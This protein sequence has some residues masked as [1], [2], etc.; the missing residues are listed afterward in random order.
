MAKTHWWI[1]EDCDLGESISV[2]V[3]SPLIHRNYIARP[4]RVHVW[5]SSRRV[6]V[7]ADQNQPA[8]GWK[9]RRHDE[10]SSCRRI[11]ARSVHSVHRCPLCPQPSPAARPSPTAVHLC[12]LRTSPP[13]V[14]GCPPSLPTT[15]KLQGMKP[16]LPA[17]AFKIN[18]AKGKVQGWYNGMHIE[19]SPILFNYSRYSIIQSLEACATP[20]HW[21]SSIRS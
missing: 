7:R 15:D 11:H 13:P 17:N 18:V 8:H 20:R 5:V 21:M 12:S 14:W 16:R 2:Q 10:P 4:P 6:K 3:L 9:L 19:L 1:L